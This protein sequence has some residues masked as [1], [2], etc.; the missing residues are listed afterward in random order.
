MT[1]NKK[2]KEVSSSKRCNCQSLINAPR[3]MRGTLLFLLAKKIDPAIVF[4]CCIF[5]ILLQ[6]IGNYVISDAIK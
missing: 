1:Q 6:I 5:F 3:Y 2:P 4:C